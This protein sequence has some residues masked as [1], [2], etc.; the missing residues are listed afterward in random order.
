MVINVNNKQDELVSS[1][2][3][4]IQGKIILP[5]EEKSA[6]LNYALIEVNERIDYLEKRL[7]ALSAAHSRI[8]VITAVSVLGLAVLAAVQITFF[9]K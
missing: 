4:T 1:L 8:K 9:I 5:A 3:S 7:S 6:A 2:A